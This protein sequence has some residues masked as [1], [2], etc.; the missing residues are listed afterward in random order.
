MTRISPTDADAERIAALEARIAALEQS[1]HVHGIPFRI[2]GGTG[3]PGASLDVAGPIYSSFDPDGGGGVSHIPYPN[4]RVYLAG[5]SSGTNLGGLQIRD[6]DGAQYVRLAEITPTETVFETVVRAASDMVVSGTLSASGD[7]NFDGGNFGDWIG[8]TPGGGWSNYLGG[9][10]ECR[11]RKIAD[12]VQFTGFLQNNTGATIATNRT[13]FTFPTDC[14]PTQNEMFPGAFDVDSYVSGDG[15]FHVLTS[16]A[17]TIRGSYT[18]GAW[19]GIRG[20]FSTL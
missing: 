12:E 10:R 5:N 3:I 11:Y 18:A 6:W 1:G 20:S 8:V 4:G 14:R 19:F 9:W 7:I 16:G 2:N 17:L 13:V 15:M